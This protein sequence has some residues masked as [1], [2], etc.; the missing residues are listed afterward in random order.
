MIALRVRLIKWYHA[1]RSHVVPSLRYSQEMYEDALTP[2]V[3]GARWLDM[4]SGHRVLSNWRA[5][6]ESVV[7]ATSPFSVGIDYD[8]SS[9][10]RHRSFSRRL[11]GDLRDLPFADRSFDLATANMVLEHVEDPLSLFREVHRV[12][13]PGGQ[14]LFHTPNAWG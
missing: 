11:R 8:L 2:L 5:Q 6:Q 3:R 10:R 13:A 7:V 12:L 1:M 14:F 9:L 4:G